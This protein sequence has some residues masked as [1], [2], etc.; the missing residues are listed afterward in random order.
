MLPAGNYRL[1]ALTTNPLEM[2]NLEAEPSRTSYDIG[3]ELDD[4]LLPGHRGRVASLPAGQV[5]LLRAA[6]SNSLVSRLIPDKISELTS[7][8]S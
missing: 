3:E 2:A 6:P 4:A 7:L 1:N 8:C 5:L